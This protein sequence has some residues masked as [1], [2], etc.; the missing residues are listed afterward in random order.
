MRHLLLSSSLYRLN[1]TVNATLGVM[2]PPQPGEKILIF[3]PHED[4]ETLGCGG[5]IQQAVAAGANVRVVLMTNGEYPELSLVLE[6]RL[7]NSPQ[8]FT[9]LG[10]DR[11]RETLAA[12]HSLGLADDR[13]IFLGYPNQYLDQMW[14]PAHWR[15]TDA[16][17]SVRL[18][19]NASP[20]ANAY[21]PHTPFCGA[22]VLRDVETILQAEQPDVVITLHPNDD[23]PDH[24]PTG[25]LVEFAL[26]E[27][28]RQRSPFTV[29]CRVYMYLIHR[30]AWPSPRKY[31]PLLPLEPPARLVNGGTAWYALPLT[32]G[33]T[34]NKMNAIKLYH[35]QGGAIDPLL[36]SF[37][38]ANELYGVEPLRLWALDSAI[39]RRRRSPTPFK[40]RSRPCKTPVRISPP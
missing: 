38:R 12:L 28:R 20:Y 2:A 18:K 7:P 6:N 23:H 34:L 35:S 13:V 36:G 29:R 32:V 16:V 31:R 22:A 33:E 5:Y 15:A 10:H 17:T 3:A 27:M 9:T 39:R 21:T 11:Q 1:R 37:A 25:T 8:A 14:S 40:I 4:D 24:W 30:A 19:A 26:D